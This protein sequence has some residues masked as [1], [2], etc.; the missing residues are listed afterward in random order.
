MPGFSVIDVLDVPTGFEIRPRSAG[1]ALWIEAMVWAVGACGALLLVLETSLDALRALGSLV[2]VAIGI[3]AVV[4]VV[5]LPL[6]R[7]FRS[8]KLTLWAPRPCVSGPMKTVLLA[9]V[10]RFGLST[11]SGSLWVCAFS[12][13]GRPE[14]L[15]E[16]D[17]GH[18]AEYAKLCDW[19]GTMLPAS[20]AFR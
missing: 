10:V 5:R 15:V 14:P 2:L 3:R 7:S 4:R 6:A 9:R 11:M 13:T 18:A 1:S 12:A 17:H 8:L 20:R 19:L 16:I